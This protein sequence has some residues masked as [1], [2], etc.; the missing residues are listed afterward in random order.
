M[1][2]VTTADVS[3]VVVAGVV[4]GAGPIC[5]VTTLV[6]PGGTVTP[7]R[8]AVVMPEGPPSI[9]VTSRVTWLA[10]GELA[11]GTTV[12]AGAVGGDVSVDGY[13]MMIVITDS[14]PIIVVTTDGRGIVGAEL[15]CIVV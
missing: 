10:G 15:F 8:Y 3:G 13:P 7:M 11:A 4:A 9:V 12:S 14:A 5:K 2:V 6:A 1:I